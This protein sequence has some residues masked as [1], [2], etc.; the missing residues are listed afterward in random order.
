MKSLMAILAA[1]L[2][3]CSPA[4]AVKVAPFAPDPATQAKRLQFIQDLINRGVF[5]KVEQPGTSP[6]AWT[7]PVFMSLDFQTKTE[8]CNAV[9]SYYFPNPADTNASGLRLFDSRSGKQIGRYDRSFG[10]TLN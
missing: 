6:R 3:G 8:F 2:I 5:S 1:V 4:P 9:H 10:L 7:T